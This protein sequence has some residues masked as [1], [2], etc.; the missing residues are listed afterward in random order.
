MELLHLT[1]DGTEYT[2]KASFGFMRELNGTA[3]IPVQGMPG[4]TESIGMSYHFALLLAYNI[5]TLEEILIMM[6]KQQKPTLKRSDLEAYIEN[7]STDIEGLF[8]TVVDFLEKSN[9]CKM[10]MK[11]TKKDM[12]LLKKDKDEVEEE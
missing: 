8:K 7:E 3:K 11:Q 9:V 12:G 10:A 6:N 2:F 4:K 1:I 5:E